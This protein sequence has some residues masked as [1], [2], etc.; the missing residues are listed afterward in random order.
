ME[1]ISSDCDLPHRATI[2]LSVQL[3]NKIYGNFML[4]FT[5]QKVIASLFKIILNIRK[6]LENE[7]LSTPSVLETSFD[8]QHCI[9]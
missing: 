2:D 6:N 5:K 1:L 4:L 7:N 3:L 9:D 8:L